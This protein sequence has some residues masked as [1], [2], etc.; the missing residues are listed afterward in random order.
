MA[1]SDATAINVA[2]HC[3]NL[4]VNRPRANTR[5]HFLI[6][7]HS[8]VGLNGYSRLLAGP[9]HGLVAVGSQCTDDRRFRPATGQCRQIW[10]IDRGIVERFLRGVG[11]IHGLA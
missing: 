8:R 7:D 1:L 5:T 6:F 4:K 2:S 3:T 9:H 10:R 11:R